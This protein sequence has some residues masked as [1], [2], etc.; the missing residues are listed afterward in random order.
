M[1]CTAKYPGTLSKWK[2]I[3]NSKR[4]VDG[5]TLRS[6]H[7]ARKLYSERW[8]YYKGALALYAGYPYPHVRGLGQ[9]IRYHTGKYAEASLAVGRKG[10]SASWR[11]MD[12][13]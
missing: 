5:F 7:R 10:K 12:K 1:T 13:S 11:L 6:S 3:T 8:I 2:N 4:K 9:G